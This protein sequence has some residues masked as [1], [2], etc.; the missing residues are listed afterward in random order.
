MA[1]T[2]PH[3]KATPTLRRVLLAPPRWVALALVIGGAIAIAAVTLVPD[4]RAVTQVSLLPLTCLVCGER[5]GVDV[6]LNLLL[7]SP[8]AVG[9]TLLG[10]RPRQVLVAVGLS[11][12][13]IE[14]IQFG[15][16][17]GRDASLSDLL[18]NTTGAFLF[19]C[20]TDRRESLFL[21]D[22]ALARWLTAGALAVWLALEA[23]TAWSFTPS[24]PRT[25]YWGQ[26]APDLGFMDVFGG[27]VRGAAVAGDSLPPH[28]V[29]DSGDLRAQ[30]LA[31]G[32]PVTAVVIS[33]RPP[34]SLAPVVSA[35][36]G[37]STE[38]FLLGQRRRDAFFRLRTRVS[39]LRLR[40][41]AIAIRDA[42]PPGAG[43]TLDLS[44]SYNQGRYLLAV[45][46]SGGRQE[47]EVDASPNLAWSFVVPF[48]DF[49]L[50]Q[51]QLWFTALWVSALLLPI[52]YWAGLGASLPGVLGAWAVVIAAF[53]LLPQL[54]TLPRVHPSEW[55]AAA[56]GLALGHAGAW[57]VGIHRTREV[58]SERSGHSPRAARPP[59]GPDGA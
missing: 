20:V 41:P 8:V 5:G 21:P 2:G 28:R 34:R 54:F 19:A 17:P 39:D 32:G 47:L 22:R 36:D 31:N 7:F 10:R 1:G 27:Q 40:P 35:F 29:P 38:I 58:S 18:T 43:D 44:A 33:G 49:G 51:N 24:L 15:W 9:L 3:Q 53:S 16:L 48:R 6:I 30:L 23:G 55:A 25:T 4:P 45:T 42:F 14:A 56:V 57:S 11:S 37:R 13:A 46:T 12:L 52:G 59:R 50:G 26:W